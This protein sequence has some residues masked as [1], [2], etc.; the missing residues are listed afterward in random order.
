MAGCCLWGRRRYVDEVLVFAVEGE[1]FAGAAGQ[2][3]LI[4]VEEVAGE[5]ADALEHVDG[6]V[7]VLGGEFAGQDDVAVEDGADGVGDG[8]VHVVG[9]DEDGEE[10]GDG[11]AFA[12]AGAFE[13]AGEEEKTE[14]V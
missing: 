8:V 7:M 2:F 14:G 9:F 5:A 12:G 3:L 11:A 4:G 10:A 6:G 1:G 13:Q